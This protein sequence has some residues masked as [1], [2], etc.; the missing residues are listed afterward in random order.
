[1]EA[2]WAVASRGLRRVARDDSGTGFR[3]DVGTEFGADV[4]TEV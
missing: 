2:V 1:M 4:V 3:A